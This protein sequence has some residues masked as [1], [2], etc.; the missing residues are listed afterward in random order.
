MVEEFLNNKNITFKT[1]RHVSSARVS[2]C[3]QDGNT[4]GLLMIDFLTHVK[5]FKENASRQMFSKF[6]DFLKY[7]E[8]TRRENGEIFL[9]SSTDTIII[10]KTCHVCDQKLTLS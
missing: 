8:C 9:D 1:I 7:G 6:Q 10:K 2:P 3:F 5:N 4:E